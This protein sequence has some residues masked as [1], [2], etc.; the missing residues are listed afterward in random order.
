MFHLHWAP[1]LTPVTTRC[2]TQ[3]G[4]IVFPSI[5][6]ET[7]HNINF[8]VVDKV[9]NSCITWDRWIVIL[10]TQVLSFVAPPSPVKHRA[11]PQFTI[12]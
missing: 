6:I 9:L 1:V 5:R 8:P 10:F 3:I 4:A 12:H 7:G 11:Q 2:S